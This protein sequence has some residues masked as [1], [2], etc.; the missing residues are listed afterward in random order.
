MH[1]SSE[2]NTKKNYP[3]HLPAYPTHLPRIFNKYN[4]TT[5]CIMDITS[6]TLA[7]PRLVCTHARIFSFIRLRLFLTITFYHPP[8]H[9]LCPSTQRIAT[10]ASWWLLLRHI[11]CIHLSIHTHTRIAPRLP[12]LEHNWLL[13]LYEMYRLYPTIHY[14]P[15]IQTQTQHT[16]IQTLQFKLT[17]TLFYTTHTHSFSHL[18]SGFY[19]RHIDTRYS[20]PFRCLLAS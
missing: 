12:I 17:N 9:T 5:I 13:P 6:R 8:T 20:I 7:P 11:R 4:P 18:T 3:I 1:A 2:G 14:T 19:L 16:H 10:S 15:H